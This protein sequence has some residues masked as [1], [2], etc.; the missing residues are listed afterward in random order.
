MDIYCDESGGFDGEKHSLLIAA[1]NISSHDAGRVMKQFRKSTKIGD[2]IKGGLLSPAHRRRFF[3]MLREVDNFAAAVTCN[4][5]TSLGAWV[6]NNNMERDVYEHM[7]VEACS[8]VPQTTARQINV[9]AD[10]GRYSRAVLDN[11]SS[12]ASNKLDQRFNV[13][14]VIHFEP[15]EKTPGIQI[16]DIVANTI[17]RATACGEYDMTDHEAC[18]HIARSGQLIVRPAQLIALRPGWMNAAE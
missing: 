12:S 10:G 11:M 18:G 6:A 4:R 9:I 1:V 15:S 2:E 7:L 17:Y 16:A 8:Y 3:D 5:S 13:K 14:T